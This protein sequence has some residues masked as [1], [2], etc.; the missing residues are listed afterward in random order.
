M[1][2]TSASL[3]I[4]INEPAIHSGH[5]ISGCVYLQVTKS[6]EASTL[7][8][9]LEGREHSHAHWTTHHTSGS[10]KNR[11]SETRHHNAYANRTILYI[12]LPLARFPTGSVE[13]GR[14]E[15]PF[16]A[17]LP[18][19]L[20]S[21]MYAS[22]G[23]GDCRIHYSLRA[24]LH[25]P[26]VFTWD[27][28]AKVPLMVQSQPLPPFRQ[29]LY[30]P[31]QSTPVNL[32]CC[33]GRG[34]IT[35]GAGVDDTLLGRGQA[36]GV[37]VAVK[38]ESTAKARR[39][40]VNIT[41]SVEWRAHGHG[42]QAKRT[43]AHAEFDP[44]EIHGLSEM[45]KQTLKAARND[46]DRTYAAILET[47]TSGNQRS[48]LTVLPDARD[49]Y[50]GGVLSVR[51]YVAVRLKTPSCI[52]DPDL[53]LPVRVGTRIPHEHIGTGLVAVPVIAMPVAMPLDSEEKASI[54]TKPSDWQ[55]AIVAEPSVVAMGEAMVGGVLRENGETE[56][57]EETPYDSNYGWE[58][59]ASH[60]RVGTQEALME[61]MDRTTHALSLIKGLLE[62][63]DSHCDEAEAWR[64]LFGALGPME[65]GQITEKVQ[66]EFDQAPVAELLAR[67][68][69]AGVTT[70]HILSAIRSVAPN[71]RAAV[72]NVL[73]P[74]CADLADT[75][76]QDRISEELTDWERVQTRAVLHGEQQSTG[77]GG[78]GHTE[79][80]TKGSGNALVRTLSAKMTW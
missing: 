12:D 39:L 61:R 6:C 27:V 3:G 67:H 22:Q 55:G 18:P 47:L 78:G 72:V 23:G 2:N 40:Y 45:S 48:S 5:Q 80:A 58:T 44:R 73:A 71:Q 54:T 65:F 53:E 8:V 29:P 77:G 70:A 26:G 16:T 79:D 66:L 25:R 63:D 1:G 9:V 35:L 38:N 32:C 10:G 64:S 34:R 33:L 37:G 30:A 17:V 4:A 31:P 28:K 68:L 75:V 21:S 57:A 62:R 49:T 42:H 46:A 43:I 60:A 7:Q 69:T 51:H 19:G 36:V 15:Y 14:Y 24:R 13:P 20:P 11:H 59:A 52:T 56:Q 74:L 41:E 76:Q 50:A